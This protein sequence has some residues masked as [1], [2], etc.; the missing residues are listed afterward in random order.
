VEEEA[1]RPM[2]LLHKAVAVGYRSPDAYRSEDA[3][4]P[5]RHHDDFQR[6]VIDL[7][8]PADPFSR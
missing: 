6:M 4:D 2:G 1:A 3:L 8:M 5:L 7:A